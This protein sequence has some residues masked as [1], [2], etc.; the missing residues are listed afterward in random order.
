MERD[1]EMQAHEASEV[2]VRYES[3]PDCTVILVVAD[4]SLPNLR[5]LLDT[6]PEV[7]KYVVK[8]LAQFGDKEAR[9]L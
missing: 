5:Y 6:N 2:R 9:Q 1:N 7:E 4:E 3:S 8:S